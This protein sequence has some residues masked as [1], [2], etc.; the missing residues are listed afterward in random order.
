MHEHQGQ[1]VGEVCEVYFWNSII[2]FPE[3]TEVFWNTG[4]DSIIY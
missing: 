2:T 4:W 1:G 3:I